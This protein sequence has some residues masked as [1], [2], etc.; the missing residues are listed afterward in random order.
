MRE[1]GMSRYRNGLLG[2]ACDFFFVFSA[3]AAAASHPISVDKAILEEFIPADQQILGRATVASAGLGCGLV[4]RHYG[5]LPRIC[6]GS[7]E[8]GGSKE[9]EHNPYFDCCQITESIL[10]S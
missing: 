5:A 4:G 6:W 9:L 2:L 7:T 10:S 8:Q 3:T 1:T